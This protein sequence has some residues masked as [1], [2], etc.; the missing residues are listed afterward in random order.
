MNQRVEASR[1]SFFYLGNR[2]PLFRL[3]GTA[4]SRR[5]G[6]LEPGAN[7]RVPPSAGA[8]GCLV[9][10][11]SVLVLPLLLSA[12]QTTR[13]DTIAQLRNRQIEIKEEKIEDGREKA[14]ESYRR[15]LDQTPD[16][17][18]KPE[19]IRRLADLKVETEYG[20]LSGDTG[21]EKRAA[22]ARVPADTPAGAGYGPAEGADD[23]ERVGAREAIEL[24]KKL[25]NDY[26]TYEHNDQVLYQ[27]S[28]AYEEQGRVE[29]AMQVMDRLVREY[30]RSPYIDEVQFRRAEYFFTRRRYPDAEE[31][32]DSIVARG[33][34][35]SYFQLALYKSGWALYK[36]ER[37]DK[38][39]EQFVALLDNKVSTGYDFGQTGDEAERKRI[40]DTFRVISLSFSSL[41]GS[42]SVVEYFT[43]QGKRSYED[44][45]YSN[46]AEF[47][48]NK[49]RYSDAAAAYDTF[50]S[51]NPF[52]KASPQFQARVIEIHLA[53]RFPS[54]AIDAK[55]QFAEKFG[56]KSEY[57]QHFEPSA[58]PEV[59]VWLKTN[60]ADLARHYHALFQSP[61]QIKEKKTNFE[62]AVHW[63]RE[64]IASFPQ[65]PD[66]PALNYALADLLLE[67][68]SFD[69]AA[70]EYEKTAYEYARHEKS[71]QAGYA[72][73]YA[74]RKDFT[75]AAPEAKD[76]VAKEVVRSS[77]TFADTYPEHEKAAIVLGAAADDLYDMQ[78]YE[79]A[80]NVAR[81]LVDRFPNA[82][83]DLLRQAWLVIGLST[84]ELR[85]YSEAETAYGNLLELLPA[86]DKNRDA[87]IDNL[88][89]AIYKQ[90]EQ[91]NARGD[92]QAAA[93]HFLRVGRLAPTSRIRANAEYDAA[94]ALIQIRD[95]KTAASVLTG[96]RGMFPGHALQP[97]VT[98]KIAYV[99]QEDGQ[100]SLAA[101]EYERIE[102]ESKDDDVRR[103]ALLTEAELLEK[104]GD[105]A[106]TMAVYRRY[107]NQFPDPVEPNVETRDK[108]AE[109]LKKKDRDGYLA[110]L[111]QIVAID[112]SAGSG[113]TP[114]TRALAAKAALVLAGSTFDR[115]AEV[116]LIEPVEINLSKKKELMK[117][118]TQQFS[119]LLD[120]E[121]GDAT[122][123][124]AF[125][126]AE[127][128]ADFS[129]DLKDSERPAGLNA[130]EREEYDLAIEE[131][132]YPFEEKAIATH[133][134]NLELISRG[135]YNEWVDRSL[136]KL[137]RLVPARY[138]KPEEKSP[139]IT[140]L[141]RYAY[142]IEHPEPFA[143]QTPRKASQAGEAKRDAQPAAAQ[144]SAKAEKPAPGEDSKD[145]KGTP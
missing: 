55:K 59:L 39:L 140:S 95:W 32:Y 14:V 106:R 89:A 19:A 122:A 138:D 104:A 5:R 77:I 7:K 69:L 117:A 24:Y 130:L 108:I 113:R 67:N 50:V 33:A 6:L 75:G 47:Y 11:L 22:Q 48:F 23:L 30:P 76:Q 43:R 128:Y 120:Y 46:L 92:H 16:S 86:G 127:T 87:R 125:Y 118:A 31:A 135:V 132:A 17:A 84:Y 78:Y 26:P 124:A 109:V 80:A 2:D 72:A 64:F 145:N 34:S 57:W 90:G 133:M 137:A 36:Q 49:R 42:G 3:G 21:T 141:D 115:F 10:G 62:E 1:G 123:A 97:E 41:G 116:K 13:K 12:C 144:E 142:V 66:A 131:Q 52:H 112:A 51:R 58:R 81:R 45:V 65:D 101:D 8:G 18:L 60:L 134:S 20:L 119:Q 88:A 99:Y 53:G 44:A 98:R 63:Y 25:L 91:A 71:S 74:W 93:E 38:A 126:L 143:P 54:L 103:E 9:A 4:H 35:S 121:A 70:V 139:V 85:R 61:K 111:R 82:D 27:M 15:F 83:A 96:F 102:R 37:Y 114:R 100:L 28:R 73:I 107:V 56:L 105:Q 68:R 129:R 136:E 94:A 79:P 110:E 40:D 29:E